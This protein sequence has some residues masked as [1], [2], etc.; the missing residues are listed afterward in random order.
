MT[1]LDSR[2]TSRPNSRKKVVW[3]AVAVVLVIGIAVGLALFQP[4]RLFTRTTVDEALP[5]AA[6]GATAGTTATSPATAS[7][8]TAPAASAPSPAVAPA[9]APPKAA[10][11]TAPTAAGTTAP[12]AGPPAAG[13][14]AAGQPAAE[15]T[16]SEPPAIAPAVLATGSFVDGEHATTGT[17]SVLQLP[18]GSKYVRLEGFS[19][20][21]G[22]DVQVWVTDQQAGGDDWGKYD[23]G[24]Y[25]ELGTLKGTDGNQ[26]YAVPADADLVGLTSVVIW[27]DRFNVAFGSAAV[28]L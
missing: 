15:T 7:P 20:S 14:P 24:R 26:N 17:A 9:P 11:T 25:V 27:C 8:A 6:A 16:P 22:P 19:T 21:D 12:A 2:P 23:D 10:A 4:W 5:I 1:E 18:D 3:S 28:E 13:S